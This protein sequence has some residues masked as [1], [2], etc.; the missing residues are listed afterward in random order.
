MGTLS[1]KDPSAK[2]LKSEVVY[3]KMKIRANN[4]DNQYSHRTI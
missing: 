2:M 3:V 1:K 4:S